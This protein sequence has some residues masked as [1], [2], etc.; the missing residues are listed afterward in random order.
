MPDQ[1]TCQ[2]RTGIAPD[3]FSKEVYFVLR[4]LLFEQANDP[5]K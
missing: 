4:F 3:P 2:K 5:V 1:K